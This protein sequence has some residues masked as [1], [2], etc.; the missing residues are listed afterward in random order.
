MKN[1][2]AKDDRLVVVRESGLLRCP[3]CGF[4][5][6][7]RTPAT[8]VWKKGRL[9]GYVECACEFKY[10]YKIDKYIGTP[11]HET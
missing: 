5:P 2:D 3:R 10:Y 4:H 9:S 11:L 7:Q 1:S 8:V 6:A